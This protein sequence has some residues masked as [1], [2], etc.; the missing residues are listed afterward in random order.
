MSNRKLRLL[1]TG[2][3]GRA[4]GHQILQALSFV[5][6]KYHIVA[7]DASRFSYGLYGVDGRYIVPP[8]ASEAYL[9][10]IRRIVENEGIDVILPGTEAE[11]EVLS[12]APDAFGEN[13]RIIVNPAAAVRLCSDKGAL[14]EWLAANG[15]DVPRTVAG[16]RWQELVRECG[17]PIVGKPVRGTGAS[18][19]VAILLDE[20]EVATYLQEQ[21]VRNIVFQQ[22]VGSMEDEYTVG[23]MVTR[24]GR[25]IDSIVLHR[26]LM[27]LSL[28]VTR[29]HGD[30]VYGLSTGYSQGYVVDHPRIQSACEDLVLR[31][32]IRGPS[33]IQLRLEGDRV[34]VFEVHPRFSGTSSIRAAVGFNE[35]DTLVRNFL[36]G[37]E[38]GRLPYQR[39]VAAIRA[40]S[41]LIVPR[42]MM[43]AVREA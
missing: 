41:N 43:D 38:F 33:N 20:S 22:Y 28:G 31:I 9:P 16:T 40:L 6:D 39:D 34:Y 14:Y 19:G 26:T 15:I 18:R 30:Q 4:V 5:P 37:E 13:C 11:V 35:P 27:G 42:A 8:A 1:V 7:T 29:R 10:A 32:G 3:G 21:D 23:V 12:Q 17:F 25:I 2:V 24:D 36:Y